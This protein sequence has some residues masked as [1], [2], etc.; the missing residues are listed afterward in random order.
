[1]CSFSQDDPVFIEV[2]LE[3]SI[4]KLV[5]WCHT[6]NCV[7]NMT[8]DNEICN[9]V[10]TVSISGRSDVQIWAVKYHREENCHWSRYWYRQLFVLT[11]SHT[12]MFCIFKCSENYIQISQNANVLLFKLYLHRAGSHQ[13]YSNV[14]N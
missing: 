2:F 1:M 14:Y 4:C 5:L 13:F 7:H 9:I 3:R 6:Y 11:H 8:S 10:I 12:S